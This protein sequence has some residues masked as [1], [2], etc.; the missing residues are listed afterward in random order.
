M[1]PDT[2]GGVLTPDSLSAVGKEPMVMRSIRTPLGLW[3]A[4]KEKA[5]QEGSDI[6]TVVRELLEEYLERPVKSP[7]TY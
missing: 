5:D 3:D 4:S 1:S 2:P 7:R 6:S